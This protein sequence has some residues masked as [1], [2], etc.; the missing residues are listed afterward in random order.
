MRSYGYLDVKH[1]RTKPHFIQTD[2]LFVRFMHV[3]DRGL[4]L[5]KNEPIVQRFLSVF[6]SHKLSVNV[7]SQ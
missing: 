3:I 2:T 7:S 6:I 5:S 4:Y 1:N